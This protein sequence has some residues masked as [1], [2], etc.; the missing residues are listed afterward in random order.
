MIL[1]EQRLF[2]LGLGWL[3]WYVVAAYG[4]SFISLRCTSTFEDA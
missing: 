1:R 3:P 4:S 2:V